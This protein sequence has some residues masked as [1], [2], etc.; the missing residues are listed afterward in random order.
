[1]QPRSQVESSEVSEARRLY[2]DQGKSLPNPYFQGFG[3]RMG[4]GKR[5]SEV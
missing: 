4:L 1:M 5:C 2:Y 3:L